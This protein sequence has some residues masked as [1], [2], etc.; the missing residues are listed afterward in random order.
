[1]IISNRPPNEYINPPTTPYMWSNTDTG[2]VF[3]C[4]DNSKDSNV[5]VGQDGTIVTNE[6]PTNG[7]YYK[8]G[9]FSGGA[10][11]D[12]SGNGRDIVVNGGVASSYF[13]LDGVYLDGTAN[14]TGLASVDLLDF[15]ISFWF[16]QLDPTVMNRWL[17]IAHWNDSGSLL[18]YT[19]TT[20]G[21]K[22]CTALP[23]DDN[24]LNSNSN[25][26]VG[27]TSLEHIIYTREGTNTKIYLNGSLSNEASVV[28]NSQHVLGKLTIGDAGDSAKGWF[29]GLR[30]YDRCLDSTELLL[31]H[32]EAPL[33]V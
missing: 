13:G 23:N 11:T 5:W 3:V 24:Q 29:A 30:I 8:Q 33:V 19:S 7:L 15:T 28:S 17:S 31:L 1:M 4:I 10:A 21:M 25:T 14:D 27:K 22:G 18:L 20:F 6:I 2:E 16:K 12:I 32:S 9:S 26:N